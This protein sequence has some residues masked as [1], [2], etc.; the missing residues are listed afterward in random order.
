MRRSFAASTRL[1]VGGFAKL[2]GDVP[3]KYSDNRS[4]S[5]WPF[6]EEP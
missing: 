6:V 3:G 1:A 5:S 2:E 4:T